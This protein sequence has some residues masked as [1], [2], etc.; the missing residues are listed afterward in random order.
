MKVIVTGI[1][2]LILGAI[3][4]L[5]GLAPPGEGGD[6]PA[7]EV[8]AAEG[9][10]SVRWKMASSFP[11]ELV[12]L[13]T[14][15]KRFERRI[16]TASNDSLRMKFY[17][18]GALVPALEIFDA[19]S[20]GALDAGWSSSGYW[21]GK[22]PAMQFFAAVPFG[23]D[24]G[25]Y[26]AW[27]QFGGGKEL[28]EE[29]YAPY[30]IHPLQCGM[31]SAE[32]SGWFR[33]EITSLEDLKGLKMRF[34][35][36][37]AKVMEKL[38][39]STQLLAGGDIFPALEL[40]TIDATEFSMPAIDLDLGFYQIAK[41]YYFPGWHQPSSFLELIINKERWD[42]LSPAHQAIIEMACGDSVTVG[43]AEG[44]AMQF[45]AL[46]ELQAKGVTFHRWSPEILAALETA[47]AEVVAE[48]SANNEDF[49][50]VWE[51]LRQFREDYKLWSGLGHL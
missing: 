46:K 29:L 43:I 6:A 2:G 32:G 17:E 48:E 50:R 34:F 27:L 26:L 20:S 5:Y 35:G 14:L 1:V 7:V 30:N 21:A 4:G 47:W 18:P 15:G 3:I 40:G 38:G 22:I 33:E 12:Q 9:P 49:A 24:P 10:A 28:S 42:S 39:V 37:G 45:A 31:I 11:G 36:L 23:P 19:V 25:E 44:E 8:V 13:G 51:S 41:H 16:Q